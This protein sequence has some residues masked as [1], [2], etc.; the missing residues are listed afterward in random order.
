M[1]GGAAAD[2]FRGGS[3]TDTATDFKTSE[4]DTRESTEIF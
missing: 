4:G 3:G 1:T 2:K